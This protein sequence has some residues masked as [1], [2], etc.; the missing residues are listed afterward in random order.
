[1]TRGN[2]RYY[3][4][5]IRKGYK[6]SSPSFILANFVILFLVGL[7]SFLLLVYEPVNEWHGTT[8]ILSHFECRYSGRFSSEPVLYLYTTD[9]RCYVLNE[10]TREIP[11]QLK[12]GQQYNAVYSGDFFHDIIRGL[13]D[14]EHEY[15][16]PDEMRQS[17]K[18]E[19]IWVAVLL[20]LCI[21]VSITINSLYAYFCVQEEKKKIQRRIQIRR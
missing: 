10:N 18:T 15:I 2:V 3:L 13:E 5:V 17:Q 21:S 11:H 12:E 20:I 6:N 7:F 14:A 1:M 16:N 19:R 9:N 4:K 8:F